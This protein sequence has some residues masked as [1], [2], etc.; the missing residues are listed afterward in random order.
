V[1]QIDAGFGPELDGIIPTAPSLLLASPAPP[2]LA[3]G[4]LQTEAVSRL[5]D[6]GYFKFECSSLLKHAQFSR[7]RFL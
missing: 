5:V 7:L 2:P 1:Q 3:L 4:Q 6:P